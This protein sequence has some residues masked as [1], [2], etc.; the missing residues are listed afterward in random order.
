MNIKNIF[1]S[2]VISAIIATPAFAADSAAGAI[3]FGPLVANINFSSVVTVL[4]SIAAGAIGI[5]LAVAGIRHI[6][7]MVRGV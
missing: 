2:T 1:L 6:R 4:M 3:D 5:S 7:A